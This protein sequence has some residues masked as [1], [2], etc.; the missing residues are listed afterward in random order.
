MFSR[1]MSRW[2]DTESE[3]ADVSLL[4]RSTNI[5]LLLLLVVVVCRARCSVRRT[6]GSSSKFNTIDLC[7]FFLTSHVFVLVPDLL[8]CL[9][10]CHPDVVTFIP[11]IPTPTNSYPDPVALPPIIKIPTFLFLLLRKLALV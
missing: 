4:R 7:F 10:F 5:G 6:H 1:K 2:R 11:T 9:V 3:R 8:S